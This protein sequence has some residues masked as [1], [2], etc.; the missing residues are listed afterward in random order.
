MALTFKGGVF[1]GDRK[2]S[3]KCI[4]EKFEPKSVLLPCGD[5]SLFVG[6]SV[7]RG[8]VLGEDARGIIWHAS[9]AGT[10]KEIKERGGESYVLIEGDG[11]DREV[12]AVAPADK[13]LSAFSPEEIVERVRLAGIFG[14][15]GGRPVYEKLKASIGRS[16]RL[17]INCAESEP[18]ASADH[19]VLLERPEEVINGAKILL[20]ALSLRFAYLGIEENKYDAADAAE[21]VIGP[22]ELVRVRMLKTKY[23]QGSEKMLINALTGRELKAG[24]EAEEIGC[25]VINCR[26]CAAVFRAFA[27][28]KPL[29]HTV[30][31]VDGGAVPRAHNVQVPLGTSVGDILEFCGVKKYDDVVLGGAMAGRV[32]EGMDE[33]IIYHSSIFC[34]TRLQR[35]RRGDNCVHCGKCVAACPMQLVPTMLYRACV[36]ENVEKAKKFGLQSCIECGA[37]AYVCPARLSLLGAVRQMKAYMRGERTDLPEPPTEDRVVSFEELV[38]SEEKPLTPEDMAAESKE[39]ENG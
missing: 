6:Q 2:R 9:I 13:P 28:G 25:T 14:L 23:P 7:A 4:I 32:A 39:V 35:V 36:K 24:H 26:T 22:G 29:T 16:D 17:I 10:V 18:Y 12:S 3:A 27:Y 30:V 1:L 5:H 37:C 19:R 20:R 21:A 11:S 34:P 33:P 15:G 8:E 31:T 38:N